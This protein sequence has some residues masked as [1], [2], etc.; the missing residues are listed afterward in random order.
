MPRSHD[1]YMDV[2]L[3]TGRI[4]YWIFLIFVYSSLHLLEQVRRKDPVRAWCF[5][6]IALFAVLINLLDTHWLTL[7]HFC[8][9]YLV[10][11]AESVRFSLPAQTSAVS[12]GTAQVNE[13]RSTRV[14]AR[15]P[16]RARST[17]G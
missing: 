4:G 12:A 1:G 16:E 11:V 15:L 8:L 10:V 7:T 13:A 17:I 14:R 9:L 6:S 5:L 3:E 2:R